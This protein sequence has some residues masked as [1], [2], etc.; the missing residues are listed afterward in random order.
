MTVDIHASARKHG[1]ADAD[2]EHGMANA[3]ATEEQDHDA[4]LW[5]GPTRD[6]RLLEVVALVLEDG[7]YLAFHAMPMR[8]K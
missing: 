7:S 4:R 2:I 5:I 6:A 8:A 3:I 1:I